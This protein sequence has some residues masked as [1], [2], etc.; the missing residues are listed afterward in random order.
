MGGVDLF[1][2]RRK[3]YFCSK[4]SKKLWLRIFYVLLDL[5]VVNAHVIYK[6]TATKQF[7]QKEFI[8]QIASQL[9]ASRNSCK[10]QLCFHDPA[11]VTRLTE[12]HFRGR[13]NRRGHWCICL[14]R[15]RTYFCCSQ[16]SPS[17]PIPLCSPTN[18]CFKLYHTLE[19]LTT[20]RRKAN[21]DELRLLP[22]PWT[23]VNIVYIG[24]PH[25]F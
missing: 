11:S 16:C 2:F 8:L 19:Q 12:R 15:R 5:A 13:Q 23:A 3:T 9:I 4:K 20:K 22:S 10:R 24:R 7:T 1:D 17:D 18:P 21:A 6:E 14:Q 25:A